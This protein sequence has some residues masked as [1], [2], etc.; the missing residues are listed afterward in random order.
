MIFIFALASNIE[1]FKLVDNEADTNLKVRIKQHLSQP[2]E[3]HRVI[4]VPLQRDFQPHDL[5]LNFSEFC[6]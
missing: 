5:K 2:S 3:I 6:S 4:Y 1:S